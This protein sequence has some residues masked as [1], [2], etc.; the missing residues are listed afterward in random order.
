M[1]EVYNLIKTNMVYLVGVS[2]VLQFTGTL[3]LALFSINGI[4]IDPEKSVRVNNKP[5]THVS[6]VNGWLSAAR[7][8]LIILLVGIFLSGIAGVISL[9][10]A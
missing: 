5:I 9:I 8:G 6:I 1:I 2:A 3:L 7:I 4:K 10:S